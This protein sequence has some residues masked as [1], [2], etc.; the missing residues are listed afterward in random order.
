MNAAYGTKSLCREKWYDLSFLNPQ[1]R[2]FWDSLIFIPL[3]RMS[4][5]SFCAFLLLS[6]TAWSQALVDSTQQQLERATSVR[7]KIE[8]LNNASSRFKDANLKKSFEYSS[9]AYALAVE[10]N[11]ELGLIQALLNLG[12]YYTRSGKHETALENYL[13]A[14]EIS[15][16]IKNEKLIGQTYKVMGNGYYFRNETS[17]ALEYYQKSL[18]VNLKLKDEESAADL[19][20]NI[21]LVFIDRNK[22]DSAKGYL[23]EAAISYQKLKRLDKLANTW[24]NLGELEVKNNRYAEAI[25][26]YQKSLEISHANGLRLQEGYALNN[27][28][29]A[30]LSQKKYKEAESYGH[31]ALQIALDEKFQPLVLRAYTNLYLLNKEKGDA[32]KALQY[33]EKLDELKDNLRD[34]EKNRLMEELR[35]KYESEQKERENQILLAE[36]EL[37][38]KQLLVTR[39]LLGISLFLILG[40]SVLAFRYYKTLG[41]I[42]KSKNELIQSN[43]HIQEQREELIAQA[44]E[45]VQA[46]NEIAGMNE[47]LEKMVAEKASHIVKQNEM[48]VQYA[49]Q[50]AH[51]VR[52][53]LARIMGLMNI[54]KLKS[55]A[56][57][58]IPFLINEMDKASRELDGV[59]REINESLQKDPEENK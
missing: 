54:V 35:T 13:N 5:F 34:E 32:S 24:V 14:L 45:L 46:N 26:Y 40:V 57:E 9:Q 48:L 30:L 29:L 36:S 31:R 25:D 16:R 1:K 55:T 23:Q 11:D 44:E 22:L 18:A 8:V 19:Q 37:K 50:N 52:G 42:K 17:L 51:K 20:N 33:H 12:R 3:S 15:Q 39:S 43:A 53:P 41:E 56:A 2:N 21:A 4:R 58:E 49:Y 28:C 6:A 10:V 27:I 7:E 38:Q 59:V 47:N